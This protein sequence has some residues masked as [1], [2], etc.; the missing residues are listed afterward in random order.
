MSFTDVKGYYQSLGAEPGDTPAALKR[1][2]RARVKEAH[3]DSGGDEDG[4]AFREI[5]DAYGILGDAKQRADYDALCRSVGNAQRRAT[6]AADKASKTRASNTK[7]K[8][9]TAKPDAT[10]EDK[11]DAK[12]GPDTETDGKAADTT[13]DPTGDL[14][15]PVR[16]VRCGTVSAQPRYVVFRQILGLLRRSREIVFDGVYCR[17]CAD[18]V[19]LRASLVTWLLGWWSLPRGPIDTARALLRNMAGGEM[20]SG[21]N[22]DI[23]T[24]QAQAFA[25]RGKPALASVLALQAY[26]FRP[27]SALDALIKLGD[28]RRLKDRWKIGGVSFFL[29]ALPIGLLIAW[30][31]VWI[32]ST[33][34]A[35]F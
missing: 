16:C 27:D 28:G 3:P 35:L 19:A 32:V 21:R 12:A 29:Q 22:A 34:A 14:P 23:L 15:E 10:A 8:A 4:A 17:T 6:E 33:L 20:P 24:R 13:Q 2:Y 30:A 25:A 18:R 11:T 9:D 26:G 5:T 31:L 7:K 1:A